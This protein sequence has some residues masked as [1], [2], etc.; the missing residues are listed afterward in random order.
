MQIGDTWEVKKVVSEA[1][2]ASA[3]GSGGL[4]VFAT[5]ILVAAMEEAAFT[6]LQRSLPP[7][8]SSVGTA[9]NITHVSPT[10]VGME[11]RAVAEIVGISENG[12]LIDFT[13]RAFDEVGLIGE[14]THQR[15]IVTSDRFLAKCRGKLTKE[16]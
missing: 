16:G 12:K 7:E 1:M 5:P 3:L 9:V 11:I 10:P 15:A 13:V 14:G 8:K 4:P 6:C 2:T